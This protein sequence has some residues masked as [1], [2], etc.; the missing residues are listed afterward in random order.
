MA[1]PEILTKNL[2]LPVVGA[3]LFIISHPALVIAQCKAGIIG[4]F[5][6][7]NARPL[8]QLD[9]WLSEI[10]E[11]LDQHNADNPDQPAAPFAINLIV[12]R[13][14]MRLEKD[15]ELVIKHKVPIVITS[16]GAR[17]EVND[18]VHSYGGITLHDVIHQTFCHKAIDKGADGLIVVAAGAGGHAGKQSPFA[19]V[20]ETREWFEGPI[21]LSGSIATGRAVLAAQVVGADLAYV[22]TRFI[23]T[24]EA[25]AV[26]GYKQM[27][28]DDAAADIVG[29]T[30]FT[31]IFGNY[32][33][34]SIINA[35][36]NPDELPGADPSAMNFS[37]GGNAKAWKD[38][39]GAG[40]GLGAIKNITSTADVVA[41]MAA[42]YEAAKTK[43]AAL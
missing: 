16:L 21:L 8:E 4:S 26:D 42:E 12:H 13:S 24:H 39:W 2:R 22:G 32:L 10:R 31:G 40:Q 14:N 43:I 29:S 38:I 28:V 20:Q 36:M 7:L 9:E 15:L 30:Q 35:G 33:K 27:L 34:N 17:P 5:P 1:L 37:G 19:I 6:S 25:R 18:A 23:A 41:S 11:A 3:P